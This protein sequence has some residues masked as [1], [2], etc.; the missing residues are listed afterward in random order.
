MEQE[1]IN[2]CKHH[3]NLGWEDK[4]CLTCKSIKYHNSIY[5]GLSKEES[6]KF[7]KERTLEA[8]KYK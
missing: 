3:Q 5:G 8:F 7:F 2:K 1:K 6:L 4:D